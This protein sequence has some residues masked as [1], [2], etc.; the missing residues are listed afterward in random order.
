MPHRKYIIMSIP[1]FHVISRLGCYFSG[2]CNGV[3]INNIKIPVQL[4]EAI[5]EIIIFFIIGHSKE[6]GNILLKYFILYGAI[7]F[8]L[9][10]LRGD[11]E[12]GIIYYLSVSQ[13][14]SLIN[15][16][17]C[18]IWYIAIRIKEM[19]YNADSN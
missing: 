12:R 11:V 15:I 10:F 19:R 1:L 17:V 8:F 14:L 5:C 16:A 7:R 4:M 2:C 13:W 6:N 18:M 9:E 3:S